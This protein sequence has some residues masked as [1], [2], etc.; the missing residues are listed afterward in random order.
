MSKVSKT[1]LNHEFRAV[2]LLFLRQPDTPLKVILE[3]KSVSKS[4]PKIRTPKKVTISQ[5]CR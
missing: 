4:L 1:A 5:I 2:F 3:T